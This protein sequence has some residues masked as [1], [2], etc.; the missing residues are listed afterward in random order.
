MLKGV[1]HGHEL[2]VTITSNHL[3]GCLCQMHEWVDAMNDSLVCVVIE[4]VLSHTRWV[5]FIAVIK[6]SYKSSLEV[7]SRCNT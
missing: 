1:G 3:G 7:K 6:L 4:L 2:L 5:M